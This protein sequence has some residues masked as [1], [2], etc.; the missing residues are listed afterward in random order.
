LTLL[1]AGVIDGQLVLRVPTPGDSELLIS[2]FRDRQT[3]AAWFGQDVP[4]DEVR[5]RFK[6]LEPPTGDGGDFLALFEGLPVGFL[7]FDPAASGEVYL[8]IVL[9][10]SAQG[11]G[12]GEQSRVLVNG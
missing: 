2:W 6:S 8:H 7:A 10:R 9:S 4:M 3:R 5:R 1:T 11:K 12:L